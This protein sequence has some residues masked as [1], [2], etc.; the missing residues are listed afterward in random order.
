MNLR[1]DPKEIDRTLALLFAPG[2]VVELRIPKAGRDG[3]I[4]GYFNDHDALVRELARRNN[5]A[6]VYIT[7]N[8]CNPDLLA[9]AA[10]RVQTHAR[11]TT[12]DKDIG[13]R[14]WLLIDID[15]RRPADIS[16]TEAEHNAALEK[17]REIRWVL[18]EDNW[19]API[20]ADSG[21]GA[22]LLYRIDLPNEEASAKLVEAGLKALAAR[23]DDAV[24]AIDQTVFNAARIVKAW[25]TVTRKGDDIPV[26]PHRV[27][28]ILDVPSTL[29]IVPV[30]LLEGLAAAVSAPPP[31][32]A[33]SR[34][35]G[36]RT[37]HFDIRVFIARYLQAGDPV[38]YDGGWKWLL[39]QCPFNPDHIDGSAAV[40]EAPAGRPGFK[41]QHHSCRG[42]NWQ[43]VRGLFERPRESRRGLGSS[44]DEVTRHQAHVS[45]WVANGG[46]QEDLIRPI[47][48]EPPPPPR[49][50]TVAL[51]DVHKAFASW[52]HLPDTGVVTVAL[53]AVAAN[54]MEGDPV[55]LLLIGPPASGK[56]EM[57]DSLL[58]LP[59]MHAAGTLTEA[60]LLSGVPKKEHARDASGGLLRAIGR[61]G[62]VI[63][64]DFTSVLSMGREVRTP[65][66]AALRE[67]H[68]GAWTRHVGVDGGRTL[69]WRGK[70]VLIGGCTPII[71]QH[72]AVMASMG[73]RFLLCR[74]PDIDS[75]VQA[76]R[77]LEHVGKETAMRR[78]LAGAVSA[79]FAGLRV[80]DLRLDDAV[81]DRLSAL[82]TLVARARSAVER[83]GYHREIELIPGSE[84]PARLVLSLARLYHGILAI[85]ADEPEAWRL[86]TSV[87]LDCIPN[88]RRRVF[89]FLGNCSEQRT[90]TAVSLAIDYPTSTTRR[91]LEDLAAHGIVTRSSGGQGRADEWESSQQAKDLIGI[92]GIEVRPFPKRQGE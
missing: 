41:C 52:L 70:C 27:S 13:S 50:G 19:P 48:Q 36:P 54:R 81:A 64:K 47:E 2:T 7:L 92:A 35:T 33:S 88:V 38:P 85:G 71:D 60:A 86:V 25:G 91:T 9:R 84:R 65:L 16:S 26:R 82:A 10:N 18:G 87:A 53:A 74:L 3:V 77:A 28:R 51:A 73:E 72:H 12:S 63:C 75:Q 44:R 6:G 14:R 57:L 67:I 46:T 5:Y 11:V 24:V 68:D 59:D 29:E 37:G 45:E 4:S 34:D 21:N 79:L 76:R 66:L 20:L 22:H 17:A 1:S 42:K 61:F 58:G 89:D 62:F 69:P 43:D 55:W 90:T 30:K 78:E 83:D 31:P 15:P 56:T 80:P 32:T 8:P 39:R 23:F 49:T 40:F